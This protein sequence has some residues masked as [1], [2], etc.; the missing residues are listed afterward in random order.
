MERLIGRSLGTS[1]KENQNVDRLN[2]AI[3]GGI[4][5]AALQVIPK[6]KGTMKRKAM[7]DRYV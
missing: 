1:V 6:R 2:E 4:P 7:A 3:C 5:E